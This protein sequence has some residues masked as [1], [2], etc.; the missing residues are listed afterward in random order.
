MSL[1]YGIGSRRLAD[2][3]SLKQLYEIEEVAYEIDRLDH[4]ISQLQQNI[5]F[6][7]SNSTKWYQ[8]CL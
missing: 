5:T 2:F 7:S 4:Q 3:L 1:I 6:I 8:A